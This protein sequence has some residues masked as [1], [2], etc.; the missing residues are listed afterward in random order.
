MAYSGIASTLLINGATA[1]ST[2]QIP[3]PLL[4]DSTCSIK[5]QSARAQILRETTIF[6]WDEASM[7]PADALKSGDVLLRDITQVNRPFGG[8]GRFTLQRNWSRAPL[9]RGRPFAWLVY[10]N[11]HFLFS[12]AKQ[13]GAHEKT[14]FAGN[15]TEKKIAKKESELCGEALGTQNLRGKKG[16]R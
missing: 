3:I 14:A 11:A 5:R 12:K 2:F 4:P 13:H 8:K 7:I 1:H 10:S 6:I 15:D 16:E 9:L